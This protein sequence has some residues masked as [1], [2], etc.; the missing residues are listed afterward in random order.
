MEIQI[1]SWNIKSFVSCVRFSYDGLTV[2]KSLMTQFDLIIIYEVSRGSEGPKALN[3]L[4]DE[5]NS[6]DA[7]RTYVNLHEMT[8]GLGKEN[9]R[10]GVIYD[11]KKLKVSNTTSQRRGT[12]YAGGRLPM[13]IDV[14]RVKQKSPVW[15]LCAWHAPKPSEGLLISQG[16]QNIKSN[17]TDSRG[18][19]TAIIL[20]DFNA[21]FNNNRLTIPND[22]AAQLPTNTTGKSTTLQAA[23]T[24]TYDS[25]DD[26]LTGNLYD[27][28]IV[29]DDITVT[30]RGVFPLLEWID[31]GYYPLRNKYNSV[32][33]VYDFYLNKISDHLPVG[34]GVDLT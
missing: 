10:I 12:L 2:L 27:N 3:K 22:Y 28:F 17:L 24:G 14:Q 16:W 9:D 1:L 34:L 19:P 7:Q 21:D 23:D 32:Q 8:N 31:Q 6:E 20:G 15:E 33:A 5:L 18:D 26:R 25:L 4:T 13:Y 29:H 30:I 11:S